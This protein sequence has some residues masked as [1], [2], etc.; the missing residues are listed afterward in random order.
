MPPPHQRGASQTP[1]ELTTPNQEERPPGYLSFPPPGVSPTPAGSAAQDIPASTFPNPT[2]G[3]LRPPQFFQPIQ[4]L[5]QPPSRLEPLPPFEPPPLLPPGFLGPPSLLA[6][7]NSVVI[8]MSSNGDPWFAV[9]AHPMPW[10][11]PQRPP[12]PTSSAARP[13]TLSPEILQLSQ[14]ISEAIRSASPISTAG[15]TGTANPPTALHT[16][17]LRCANHLNHELF[18]VLPAPPTSP[19]ARALSFDGSPGTA[20]RASTSGARDLATHQ[21][22]PRFGFD[23]FMTKTVLEQAIADIKPA[24]RIQSVFACL[25]DIDKKTVTSTMT[26]STSSKLPGAWQHLSVEKGMS[27]SCTESVMAW[28]DTPMDMLQLVKHAVAGRLIIQIDE[29]LG[30]EQQKI[31]MQY[32]RIH[33]SMLEFAYS[34]FSVSMNRLVNEHDRTLVYVP[35][36]V[37]CMKDTLC[38]SEMMRNLHAPTALHIKSGLPPN[39]PLTVPHIFLATLRLAY[40]PNK[41]DL[42]KISVAKVFL[43]PMYEYRNYEQFVAYWSRIK[44][45]YYELKGRDVHTNDPIEERESVLLLLACRSWMQRFKQRWQEKGWPTS[46]DGLFEK[47]KNEM[48]NEDVFNEKNRCSAKKVYLVRNEESGSD[49]NEDYAINILGARDAKRQRR[50]D[51]RPSSAPPYTRTMH[52]K[53]QNRERFRDRNPQNRERGDR[54]D[55]GR[56][57]KL[58]D[59]NPHERDRIGHTKFTSTREDRRYRPSGSAPPPPDRHKHHDRRKQEHVRRYGLSGQHSTEG[60]KHGTRYLLGPPRDAPEGW[61]CPHCKRGLCAGRCVIC[62]QEASCNPAHLGKCPHKHARF[63]E[64]RTWSRDWFEK[65]QN[66]ACIRCG[67]VG[68]PPHACPKRKE[69]QVLMRTTM[70]NGK[71]KSALVA[72]LDL[73][74]GRQAPSDEE[75]EAWLQVSETKLS[76]G[77]RDHEHCGEAHEYDAAH[78]HTS[79]TRLD[80][81]TPCMDSHV[82][83]ALTSEYGAER[84]YR[85]SEYERDGAVE[86][87]SSGCESAR[88]D[89][90]PVYTF[91]TVTHNIGKPDAHADESLIASLHAVSAIPKGS[92]VWDCGAMKSVNKDDADAVGYVQE[93]FAKLFTADG[94]KMKNRGEADFEML[95]GT[96]QGQ[97]HSMLRHAPI[98]PDVPMNIVSAGEMFQK[99]YGAAHNLDGIYI[100]KGS[101]LYGKVCGMAYSREYLD[102]ELGE[103][104]VVTPDKK[105]IILQQRRPNLFTIEP[106]LPTSVEESEHLK[107]VRN[108]NPK[109][110][111]NI[112]LLQMDEQVRFDKSL[113]FYTSEAQQLL[114]RIEQMHRSL[115]SVSAHDSVIADALIA[116]VHSM[117]NVYEHLQDSNTSTHLDENVRQCIARVHPSTLETVCTRCELASCDGA[118]VCARIC[119]ECGSDVQGQHLPGY[120]CGRRCTTSNTI[121]TLSTKVRDEMLTGTKD[122]EDDKIFASNMAEHAKL[123]A[124]CATNPCIVCKHAASTQSEKQ[125]DEC[126]SIVARIDDASLVE[127]FESLHMQDSS[128]V[129]PVTS[130]SARI[131]TATPVNTLNSA[132]ICTT[133]RHHHTGCRCTDTHTGKHRK[134][135]GKCVHKACNR[136]AAFTG[137]GKICNIC[138]PKQHLS[139]NACS[140]NPTSTNKPK[141]AFDRESDRASTSQAHSMDDVRHVTT[142]KGD[143]KSSIFDTVLH[144][145]LH[146]A[147]MPVLTRRK[148]NMDTVRHAT[149]TMKH[150]PVRNATEGS[151]RAPD[152]PVRNATEGSSRAPIMPV[153][154]ATEGS[155]IAPDMPVR[156]ATDDGNTPHFQ[157][158]SGS[159][160]TTPIQERIR[161]RLAFDRAA[162]VASGSNTPVKTGSNAPA[163]V[164][165]AKISGA[166]RKEG[167][168]SLDRQTMLSVIGRHAWQNVLDSSDTFPDVLSFTPKEWLEML[169]QDMRNTLSVVNQCALSASLRHELCM[170]KHGRTSDRTIESGKRFA[171]EQRTLGDTIALMAR[172]A[173]TMLSAGTKQ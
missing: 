125:H 108:S 32:M 147:T 38:A 17:L 1:G 133:C 115:A 170:S 12:T 26:A 76:D 107:D 166:K 75:D 89:I 124:Q 65:H 163:A 30:P 66:E 128:S 126:D 13:T 28:L 98:C 171:H 69:R 47:L 6:T 138:D 149:E 18:N 134:S 111:D 49:S 139:C 35:A 23:A 74:D 54:G 110:A 25:R 141:E 10:S 112:G 121:L 41:D 92:A 157:P 27:D 153:R 113:E 48:M 84:E 100:P 52:D 106:M 70:H 82:Y 55:R 158:E 101:Y 168:T 159:Y 144:N 145:N 118:D 42:R 120:T 56:G 50:D 132:G 9:P 94:T 116:A 99:G 71:H 103:H 137:K 34:P 73:K 11:T 77:C 146:H 4:S 150:I 81:D 114:G 39:L 102:F 104:Y 164:D 152:M 148:K 36:S 95:C 64:P 22:V 122:V 172:V 33:Q 8:G 16:I 88:S 155:S 80:V 59:R 167:E 142:V 20:I 131:P 43:Q 46:T 86:G 61:K 169:P 173:E 40:Q 156:N 31:C 58:R 83:L 79:K 129:M 96:K 3:M 78:V 21:L 105:Q 29:N 62:M 5:Q 90:L 63:D 85:D 161:S 135:K 93:S 37:L 68:H 45:E 130:S 151:S 14:A 7:L 44:R 53:S 72:F 87:G 91:D 154:N 109:Y 160:I 60:Q 165:I 19:V 24:D 162:S 51:K 97:P 2:A 117:H 127:A 140:L 136:W 123:H 57:E 67:H 143:N 15:A 119:K